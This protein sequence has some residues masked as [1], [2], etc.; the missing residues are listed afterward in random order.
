MKSVKPKIKFCWEC[1]KK[2]RGNHHSFLVLKGNV[3]TL[4]VSCAD[5]LKA[6]RRFL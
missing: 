4:H 6:E 5:Q 1:G 3:H 2:L